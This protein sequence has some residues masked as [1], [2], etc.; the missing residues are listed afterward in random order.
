MLLASYTRALNASDEQE[1]VRTQTQTRYIIFLI[2]KTWNILPPPP[3]DKKKEQRLQTYYIQIP[4]LNQHLAVTICNMQQKFSEQKPG[5][6]FKSQTTKSLN[7]KKTTKSLNKKKLQNPSLL[8]GLPRSCQTKESERRDM[9]SLSHNAHRHPT[10]NKRN[11]HKDLPPFMVGQSHD[12][13]T[14]LRVAVV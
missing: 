13:S 5:N 3:P 12:R 4:W 11:P 9:S 7:K 2:Q 1:N 10:Q 8:Q 14:L 6:Q